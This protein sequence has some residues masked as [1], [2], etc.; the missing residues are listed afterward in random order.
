MRNLT[1]LCATLLALSVCGS[2]QAQAPDREREA[3]RRMQQQMQKLQQTNTALEK[4]KADLTKRATDAEAVGKET[5]AL[6]SQNAALR[7]DAGQRTSAL[8]KQLAESREASAKLQAEL[9]ESRKASGALKAEIDKLR[10]EIKASTELVTARE[11]TL[12]ERESTLEV[13]TNNNTVLAQRANEVLDRLSDGRCKASSDFRWDP[14]TKLGRVT[15]ENELE[16]YRSLIADQ[17]FVRERA[18]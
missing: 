6:R 14:F 2:A 10:A 12:K 1:T 8:E 17:R 13:C 16:R 3:L 5:D 18:R 15:F 11:G 9:A 4:E 7:R